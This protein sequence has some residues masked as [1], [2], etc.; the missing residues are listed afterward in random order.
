M[1]NIGNN[2]TLENNLKTEFDV[3]ISDSNIDNL[4]EDFL[5]VFKQKRTELTDNF[6]NQIDNLKHQTGKITEF[7]KKAD[8]VVKVD[9]A[10]NF[11]IQNTIN[12]FTDRE[13]LK[14]YFE[15]G[16]EKFSD[17]EKRIS[18]KKDQYLSE[19]DEFETEYRKAVNNTNDK[20]SD[21]LKK[22]VE[23]QGRILVFLDRIKKDMET[24]FNQVNTYLDVLNTFDFDEYYRRYDLYLKNK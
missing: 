15:N 11:Y 6:F 1:Q 24:E 5:K 16:S 9:K 3:E 18:E 20:Q 4:E 8:E 2:L 12:M 14:K 19:Y 22:A 23:V 7:E 10:E 17:M 13:I 21:R